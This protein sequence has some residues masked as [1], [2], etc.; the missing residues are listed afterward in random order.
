MTRLEELIYALATVIVRYHDSQDNIEAKD[1]LVTAVDPIIHRKKSHE[2]AIEIIQ[3]ENF[4]SYLEG[5]IAAC[6]KGYHGREEFLIFLLNK[7]CFLKGQLDIKTPFKEHE[8]KAFQEQ[9]T[10]LFIDF[11][12][13][14][15]IKKGFKHPVLLQDSKVKELSGLLNDR[16]IGSKYCN[17]GQLLIDEV[18]FV[19]HMTPDDSN[20]E[21]KDIAVNICSEQQTLLELQSA[22][23]TKSTEESD[24]EAEKLELE[25]LKLLVETQK[26]EFETRIV[27]LTE[28]NKV[29]LT[30]IDA[31]TSELEKSKAELQKVQSEFENLKRQNEVEAPFRR[32]P[33][34]SP[35]FGFAGI[36]ALQ[37]QGVVNSRFFSQSIQNP[38]LSSQTVPTMDDFD[39]NP[40]KV[41]ME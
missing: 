16:Y 14:L 18:L 13:L 27:E 20:E 39:E 29:L 19:L 8:L 2:R 35:I 34:Y 15:N 31:L 24:K 33:A 30:S 10:Q 7:I 1:K 17:S 41:T 5:R 12:K 37:R 36:P 22:K 6:T 25:N 38:S 28:K 32:F 4:V 21:L 9:L 40:S 11:R 3:K 23:L 26:S